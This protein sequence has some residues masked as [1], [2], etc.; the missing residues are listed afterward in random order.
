[1]GIENRNIPEGVQNW[2]AP[3]EDKQI[4]VPEYKSNRGKRLA[5]IAAAFV[6]GL[7]S[8]AA[9]IEQDMNTDGQNQ[10]EAQAAETENASGGPEFVV[11]DNAEVQ[12]INFSDDVLKKRE[13]KDFVLETDQQRVDV[14][15]S[16]ISD[17]Y[18]WISQHYSQEE[19]EDVRNVA[20]DQIDNLKGRNT[21][22]LDLEDMLQQMVNELQ[23]DRSQTS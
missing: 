9:I 17:S 22:P 6:I 15:K 2:K 1:M 7:G 19:A 8:G 21:G 14:M 13:S 10:N 20:L 12:T 4:S 5:E 3:E 11:D 18:D 16:M 23:N